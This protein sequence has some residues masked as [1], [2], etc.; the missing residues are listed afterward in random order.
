VTVVDHMQVYIGAK[1]VSGQ[2]VCLCSDFQVFQS[3]H[4]VS[5]DALTFSPSNE[6]L[7]LHSHK[8]WV[9]YLNYMKFVIIVLC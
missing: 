7:I 6:Y 9:P 4:Y 2:S 3:A 5:G 8:P 1:F